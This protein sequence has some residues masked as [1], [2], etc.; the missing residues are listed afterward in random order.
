MDF[1]DVPILLSPNRETYTWTF[2]KPENLFL[3]ISPHSTHPP[4]L[5][6][7]LIFGLLWTCFLQNILKEDFYNM[8][9]LLFMHLLV[10][11]HKPDDIQSLFIEGTNKHKTITTLWLIRKYYKIRFFIWGCP[12]FCIPYHPIDISYQKI[13][14]ICNK[15]CKEEPDSINF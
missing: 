8:I 10:C 13:H 7:S 6:K 2:Q 14:E 1:L 4:G 9:H 5:I 15:A 12:I 3:Y 11:G